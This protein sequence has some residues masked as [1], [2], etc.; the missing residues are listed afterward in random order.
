MV[1]QKINAL[2]FIYPHRH[3][4]QSGG[5]RKEIFNMNKLF[6]K[7]A[8]L[9]LGLSLAAGVGVVAGGAKKAQ[10][11]NADGTDVAFSWADG[12][13]SGSGTSCTITWSSSYL[14]I[15]QTKGSSSTN[16]NSSY[17]SAPRFYKQHVLTFTPATGITITKI[18][19]S[20]DFDGTWSTGSYSE[21][22]WTGSA[23]S[24]FTYTLN[25]RRD[26]PTLT[27]SYT[28]TVADVVLNTSNKPYTSTSNSNTSVTTVT[29]GG[30]EYE[31]KGGY[32]YN[33]YLSF[34]RSCAGAYLQNNT[35]FGK[36]IDKILINFNT[37]AHSHFTMYEGNAKAPS[38]TTVTV[39]GSSPGNVTYTFSGNNE[40]FR[41]YY[42][43]SQTSV[44]VNIV[45]IGI[46]L[47]A[48]VISNYSVVYNSNSGGTAPTDST[49]Y[50]S[51]TIESVE[52][53]GLGSM[54]KT[55]HTCDGWATTSDGNKAYDLGQTGVNLKALANNSG[56]V[57]LYAHWTV[58]S[59]SVTYKAGSHG[60]GNDFVETGKLYNSAYN[61]VSYADTGF[62]KDTGYKFT[63]WDISGD[64]YAAGAEITIS[65]D[66]TVTAL[67]TAAS[68]VTITYNANGG[69]NTPSSVQVYEESVYTLDD[70][71]G[72]TAPNGK[73]FGGWTDQ[74]DYVYYPGSDVDVEGAMT[75]TA[76]WSTIDDDDEIIIKPSYLD[77]SDSHT[78]DFFGESTDG[79]YYGGEPSTGE[80]FK[81]YSPTGTNASNCYDSSDG[82]I[83]MGK[84][85]ACF[86]NYTPFGKNISNINIC[87]PT[88]AAGS[89]NMLIHFSNSAPITDSIS[90]E[91]NYTNSVAMSA[92]MTNV[93]MISSSIASSGFKYFRIE[94]SG[95]KNSQFQLKIQ[96][97][98]GTV[99]LSSIAI[100]NDNLSNNSLNV[101]LGGSETLGL[102]FSPSNASDQAVTWS[103]SDDGVNDKILVNQSGVVSVDKTATIGASATI[104]ATPHDTHASAQS[105][106]V[107]V[108]SAVAKTVDMRN[109]L[110][111]SSSLR[112]DVNAG[113]GLSMWPE[114]AI[115]VTLTDDSVIYPSWDDANI[116]WYTCTSDSSS[117]DVEVAD[118]STFFFTSEIKRMRLSY[119]GVMAGSRTF[120]E[121]D[122][123]AAYFAQL[124][125]TISCDGGETAPSTSD[126]ED[127]NDFWN[128]GTTVSSVGKAY[129]A[130][131]TAASKDTELPD[132]PTVADYIACGLARYDYI[133]AKYNK[134][135]GLTTD[136]PDFINRNPSLSGGAKVTLSNIISENNNAVAIIIV[137]SMVSVTAI[138]GYFFIK[139]RKVN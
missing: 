99:N 20:S 110:E 103:S 49:V 107:V 40:F 90:G 32:I 81:K 123:T 113:Q 6:T 14:T 56:V 66:T 135:L 138:G 25:T 7:A 122:T 37:A 4:Y 59:Y 55:G 79:M 8:K 136:Y 57:T 61:L 104:T 70:G 17:I 88:G 1:V 38:T 2:L 22:T 130:I 111:N 69:S 45:S 16:V 94:V 120:I 33:S 106:T 24:Q 119:G 51:S 28:G 128:D 127:L 89:Y 63:G 134:L 11:V 65:G 30:I 75:F 41:L 48:P 98:D 95:N 78:G 133:V 71:S 114:N 105:I 129:L 125:L 67:Y 115:K 12:T 68:Q 42:P 9:V 35:S 64:T 54:T 5:K 50:T 100:T 131:A 121:V 80:A 84:N 31:N 27:I 76:I 60:Q 85:G 39:S 132:N 74:D 62:E 137:I 118:A 139:K 36:N 116:V 86:Y 15:V 96:L 112:L 102:T 93:S 23:S 87:A 83:F 10:S 101:P 34:N 3:I 26:N 109:G 92:T 108:S 19:T 97:T 46:Y 53:A 126:W 43:S 58:N 124:I 52:L 18:T 77:L 13:S 73:F 82:V 47:K 44:Y 29:L 72:M 91:G 117:N 21:N